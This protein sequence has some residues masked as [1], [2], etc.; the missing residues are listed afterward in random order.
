MV[1][2]DPAAMLISL[3]TA[4]DL[5]TLSEKTSTITGAV[6]IASVICSP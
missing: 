6:S 5:F 1:T 2:L 4:W 3:R